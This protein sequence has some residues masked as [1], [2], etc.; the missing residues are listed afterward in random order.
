MRG[1][2][3]YRRWALLVDIAVMSRR[4]RVDVEISLIIFTPNNFF[5]PSLLNV[6][7]RS[8]PK[9]ESFTLID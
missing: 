2:I 5:H 7:L 6:L 3:A 9:T 1:R 8:R 4:C